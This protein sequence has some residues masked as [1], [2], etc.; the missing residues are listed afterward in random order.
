MLERGEFGSRLGSECNIFC[1]TGLKLADVPRVIELFDFEA[2][3]VGV[4][5]LKFD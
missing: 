2:T 3:G 4:P 5:L 1:E